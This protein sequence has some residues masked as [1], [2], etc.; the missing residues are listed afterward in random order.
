MLHSSS[1]YFVTVGIYGSVFILCQ[2][3]LLKFV[4]HCQFWYFNYNFPL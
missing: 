3:P 1:D 2:I 4:F